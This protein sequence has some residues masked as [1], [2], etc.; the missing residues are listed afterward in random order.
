MLEI[1][2]KALISE[3]VESKKVKING[4][5]TQVYLLRNKYKDWWRLR[6]HLVA[7]VRVGKENL[8]LVYFCTADKRGLINLLTKHPAAT[9]DEVLLIVYNNEIYEAYKPMG[10]MLL[11]AVENNVPPSIC[12]LVTETTQV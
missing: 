10:K 9:F 6:E 1:C 8:F 7:E 3:T 4:V 12:P 11:A 2:E 5:E